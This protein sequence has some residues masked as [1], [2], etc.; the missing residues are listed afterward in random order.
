MGLGRRCHAQAL[1]LHDARNIHTAQHLARPTPRHGFEQRLQLW[2]DVQQKVAVGTVFRAIFLHPG[3]ADRVTAIMEPVAG[4]LDERA[5]CSNA[6]LGIDAAKAQATVMNRLNGNSAAHAAMLA[7]MTLR[8]C[9]SVSCNV[10]RSA[11]NRDPPRLRTGGRWPGW[12]CVTPKPAYY[13]ASCL[14]VPNILKTFDF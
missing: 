4:E 2:R 11:R 12:H 1:A 10:N 9:A 6:G 7:P 14:K 13:R 8:H 5:R 3:P